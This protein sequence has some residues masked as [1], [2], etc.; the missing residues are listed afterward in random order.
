VSDV[1]KLLCL[2]A[3]MFSSLPDNAASGAGTAGASAPAAA[4][5]AAPAGGDAKMAPATGTGAPVPAA[6]AQPAGGRPAPSPFGPETLIPLMI[7]GLFFY[8]IL[9]RPQQKEQ[10]RRQELLN[11]LKKNDKVVTTAGIVATVADISTDGRVVT[12]KV[13]DSTRIKFL[14]SSIQGLFEEKPD[15]AS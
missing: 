13:D 12:L 6:G 7:M 4:S 15:N 14:R 1:M 5:D 9:I 8:F 11:A 3:L 10:R 2:C